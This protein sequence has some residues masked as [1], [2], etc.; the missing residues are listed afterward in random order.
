MGVIALHRLQSGREQD[1]AALV[2]GLARMSWFIEFVS[3]I[4]AFGMSA[5][6]C[7]LL[8]ALLDLDDGKPVDFAAL[9][10]T[11]RDRCGQQL[12]ALP[13]SASRTGDQR[14][15]DSAPSPCS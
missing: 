7:D 8:P 14:G 2:Q 15:A 1:G 12:P 11:V 9:E 13:W 4:T 6:R 10:A 5:A 3:R